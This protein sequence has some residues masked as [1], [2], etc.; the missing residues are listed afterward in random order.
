MGIDIERTPHLREDLL[1]RPFAG[2]DL[3][4]EHFA[5]FDATAMT[6]E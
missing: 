3:A 1:E 6:I 5:G 2:F 4:T